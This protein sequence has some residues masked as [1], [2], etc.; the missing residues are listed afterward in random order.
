MAFFRTP[1][2]VKRVISKLVSRIASRITCQHYAAVC[3]ELSTDSCAD[4]GRDEKGYNW[5]T[6]GSSIGS[7]GV[8]AIQLIDHTKSYTKPIYKSRPGTFRD[9][10]Q[11]AIHPVR[12]GAADKKSPTDRESLKFAYSASY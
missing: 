10:M 7:S 3:A 2:L 12:L 11:P 4:L 5:V 6:C 9:S 1:S 8:H